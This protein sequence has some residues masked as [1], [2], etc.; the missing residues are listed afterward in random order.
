[1]EWLEKSG[2]GV[3]VHDEDVLGI[4]RDMDLS[5]V[6][7]EE[8]PDLGDMDDQSLN[9]MNQRGRL[10]EKKEVP[11]ICKGVLRAAMGRQTQTQ[12]TD[13]GSRRKGGKDDEEKRCSRSQRPG[14]SGGRRDVKGESTG[15]VVGTGWRILGG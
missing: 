10:E 9:V 5:D 13:H 11:R 4:G 2:T 12:E 15:D 7:P 6:L 3:R 14:W 1:M 8:K